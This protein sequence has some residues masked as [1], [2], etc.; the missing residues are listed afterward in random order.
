MNISPLG[1][2]AL[3]IELGKEVSPEINHKIRSFILVLKREL[4]HGVKELVPAYCTVTLFYDPMLITYHELTAKLYKLKEH[5]GSIELPPAKIIHIPTCYGGEFGRDLHYV[6]DFHGISVEEVISLHSK[7]SYLIYMI[8]FSPGFPYL[9]GMSRQLATPRLD[10]PRERVAAGSV[11]IAGEQTGIY[12]V[13]TPGGWRIIGKTPLRLFDPD[14]IPPILLEAGNYIKFDP[15][16]PEE[17]SAIEHQVKE[18][19]ISLFMSSLHKGE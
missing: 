17:Y 9:G 5:L 19:N 13:E 1:D 4:I 2:K 6:A 8:G 10:I 18:K 7:T 15:I 3:R 12:S 14:N 11:G 16:S